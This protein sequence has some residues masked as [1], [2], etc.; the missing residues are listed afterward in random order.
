MNCML[1]LLFLD[2]CLHYHVSFH[3]QTCPHPTTFLYTSND[4]TRCCG[5]VILSGHTMPVMIQSSA[6]PG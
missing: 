2:M 6:V 3:C 4:N 5:Y 1:V